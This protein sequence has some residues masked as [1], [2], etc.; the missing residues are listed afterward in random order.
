MRAPCG[1]NCP[2]RHPACHG[3]CEEYQA[4]AEW[5]KEKYKERV[6]EHDVFAAREAMLMPRL[7]RYKVFKG[8]I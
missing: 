4:F 5:S 6:H 3:Q 7:K 2:K 1:K 8:R